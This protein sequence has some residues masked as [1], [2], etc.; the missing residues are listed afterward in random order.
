MLIENYG[1]A[2]KP[3]SSYFER[4][5]YKFQFQFGVIVKMAI[6]ALS[7]TGTWLTISQNTSV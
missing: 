1:E 7:Q 5:Y 2:R 3:L 6:L 4:L